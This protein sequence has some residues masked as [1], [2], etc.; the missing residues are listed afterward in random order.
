MPKQKLLLVVVALRARF[1]MHAAS[2]AECS[3][4]DVIVYGGTPGGIAAAI[5]AGRMKKKVVLL[6][7]TQHVGGMMT[8]GL[9]RTD[10]VPRQGAEMVYGGIAQEFLSRASQH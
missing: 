8:S 4:A 3:T 7:P 9:N 5:R 1:S 2:A 10:A 6:E